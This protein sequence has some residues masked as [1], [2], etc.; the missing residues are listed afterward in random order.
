MTET[1]GST[2]TPES[3]NPEGAEGADGTTPVDG[4]DKALSRRDRK[5]AKR[6]G[7]GEKKSG[8]RAKKGVFARLALFYRQI[9]AELRKVV[10]PSR[11]D[12][13]NYTTVVVVFVVVIMGLVASLDFGFAKLSLWIFG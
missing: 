9:I 10:W 6:S 7:D 8:K 5:R 1:T 12:L 2:A 4:E 11:S 3:G 13:I